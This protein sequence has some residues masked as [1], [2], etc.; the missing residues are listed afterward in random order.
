MIKESEQDMVNR[1]IKEYEELKADRGVL[2]THLQDVADY[3]LPRKGVITRTT[4]EGEKLYDEL[5]DSTGVI[6][7]DR[8]ATGMY[9]YMTPAGKRWQMLAPGIEGEE[10]DQFKDML[11]ASSEELHHQMNISNFPQEIF[12]DYLDLGTFGMGNI[13]VQSGKKSALNYQTRH[14]SEYVVKEDYLGRIDTCY[15][16]FKENVRQAVQRFGLGNAGEKVAKLWAEKKFNEKLEF[17]HVQTPNENYNPYSNV[18]DNWNMPYNSLW[19]STQDKKLLRRSGVKMLRYIVHR[20][21]KGTGEINGRSPS[22]MALPEEKIVGKMVELTVRN[23]EQKVAP[24]MLAPSGIFDEP[25]VIEPNGLIQYNPILSPNEPKPWNTGA[26]VKLGLE[27][28]EQR[29]NFI[30]QALY[31][32]IFLILMDDKS[33]TATEVLEIART[34]L[35]LLSP[36]FGRLKSELYDPLVEVSLFTLLEIGAAPPLPIGLPYRIEYI[37]T[38]ALALKFAEIQAWG[39]TWANVSVLAQVD[40]SVLDNY[41]LDEISRGIG[42]NN[43]IPTRWLRSITE[44]T[45]IREQRA[46]QMAEMAAKQEALET[47]DV[48]PKVSKKIEEGSVLAEMAR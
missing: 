10:G 18:V 19:I 4:Q 37:S 48:I 27:M 5:Y 47:A 14:V 41:N 8:F 33:R 34:K 24:S 45:A 3:F 20:F 7:V 46:K 42:E 32:D 9:N 2:D 36:S 30:R 6:A 31:N 17:L 16:K 28:E 22:M 35:S 15:L 38:L 39:S 26:D 13:Y 44:R 40:P 12:D 43:G 11:S 23:A 29:R 21:M 1:Y 25:P